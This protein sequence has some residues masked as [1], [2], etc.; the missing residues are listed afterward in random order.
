MQIYQIYVSELNAHVKFKVLPV[1][2]IQEFLKKTQTS[3]NKD[4]RKDILQFIVF[5]LNTDV[6]AALSLLSRPAAERALE[7]IYAG[8]VMLNPG[9]DL[10]YWVDIAYSTAPLDTTNSS[11]DDYTLDQVKKI[12]KQASKAKTSKSVVTRNAKQRKMPKQKFL[13]L[14]DYLKSNVIG[15]N[16]AVDEIVSALMRS[17]ADIND[18]NRPLGVF[19]FA[20]SSGVGKT[21]LANALHKYLFGDE[22]P[23]VRMDCGEFQHKHENQKLLGSP[24]G[25]VGHDEGGQLT[26]QIKSNPYSV[27]LID[28]VEKAHQDIWNTFLRI[29]DEGI[30][31]DNKGEL[32]DFRNT[33]IIM[34]TNLGNEKTVENLI[35]T[36]AGFTRNVVFNRRTEEIPTRSIV[37]KNTHQ[38]I[39]KYFRPEFINRI[40]KIVV[41]NHLNRSDCEK[42]AEIEMSVIADKLSRKGI[43][44]EY[45]DNVIDG[46]INLG[47]DTVKGARG[48]SQVRRDTIET[49]IA[50]TIVYSS[51]P[52]GT[53]FH[54]DYI[55]DNF[56]FDVQKPVKKTRQKVE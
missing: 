56:V 46:L 44:L 18:S 14:E 26:N 6:A 50:K 4:I 10:E 31:T 23:M 43:S 5:N 17:Q 13:G 51:I 12:L 24:P 2:D 30:V 32:V 40:D 42:I 41:F 1:E 48:I 45:T 7:A 36:G 25:Y 35:S 9:L 22:I 34:T 33:V 15:Q 53:I 28:E 55:D 11:N 49:P 3:K 16:E 29:F 54:I 38:A 47:I 39:D 21:H 20:G 19:L 37:E 52:K 27:V 8:C